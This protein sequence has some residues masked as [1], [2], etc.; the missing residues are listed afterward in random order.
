M[1]LRKLITT[2]ICLSLL[3]GCASVSTKEKV[4]DAQDN[5]TMKEIYHDKFGH[6]AQEVNPSQVNARP[7]A[8]GVKD[9]S[10]YTRH[11]ESELQSLFPEVPNPKLVMYVYP[12]ISSS[13]IPIP[14]YAIPFY[15]YKEKHFA[16]P[17]EIREVE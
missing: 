3:Q 10:P 4:F 7:I 15:M 14:G 2:T 6:K 9:L 11:A 13:N 1:P 12:H 5:P 8:S 17:S 16:L